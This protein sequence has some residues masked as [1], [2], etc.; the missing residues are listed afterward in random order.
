MET[1]Y[2]THMATNADYRQHVYEPAEDSFLLLD[3]LE[4]ELPA[5][6][7]LRPVIVVEIGPGSGVIVSALARALGTTAQCIAVDINEH[8]CR[9]TLETARR[10]CGSAAAAVQ[11][12]QGDLCAALRERTIDVLVFN[13]PY[14]VTADAEVMAERT[15]VHGVLGRAWAGGEAGRRVTD[16][17]VA[18]LDG[19]LT[20]EGCAFLVLI[21]ENDPPAVAAELSR[22]RFDGRIVAERKIRGEHLFVMK[23]VRAGFEERSGGGIE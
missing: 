18:Q 6:R 20:A 9:C 5:L 12:V 3:A 11:V 10:H 23:I 19:W 22:L 16:R 4:A 1:P 21:A 14:V 8:A 15:T 7:S 17:F 2:T 13:P